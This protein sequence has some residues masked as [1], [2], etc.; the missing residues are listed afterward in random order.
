M[1]RPGTVP[2]AVRVPE[3]LSWQPSE[4]ST[5]TSTLQ[6]RKPRLRA[7]LEV[8]TRQNDRSLKTKCLCKMRAPVHKVL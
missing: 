4:G 3:Q 5:V 1:H 8:N 7:W 2:K 6:R